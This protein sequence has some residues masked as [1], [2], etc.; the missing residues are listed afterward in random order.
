[1]TECH[2]P[3]SGHCGL[4]ILPSFKNYCVLSITHIFFEVGIPTFVCGCILG[5]GSVTYQ[6]RVIM[7]L[8][9]D[10]V[11]RKIMSGASLLYFWNRNLKV[12]V[13]MHL[14]MTKCHIS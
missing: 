1:M 9:S 3:F 2:I 14:L 6:F 12:G 13:I 11:F 7:I 5:W 4:D 8:T 10:L